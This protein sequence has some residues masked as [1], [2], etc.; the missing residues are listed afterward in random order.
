MQT[1]KFSGN[2]PQEFKQK[3]H[4]H[5]FRITKVVEGVSMRDV[6][7]RER[8]QVTDIADLGCARDKTCNVK[9]ENKIETKADKKQ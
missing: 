8:G 2:S 3:V 9:V 4:Q 7:Q 1:A 5:A 6:L